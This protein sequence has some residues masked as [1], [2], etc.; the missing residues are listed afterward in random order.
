[1]SRRVIIDW[2]AIVALP[3][4]AVG[5]LVLLGSNIDPCLA[6][7]PSC[8]THEGVAPRVVVVPAAV[9]WVLAAFDIARARRNR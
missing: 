6:P 7:S 8:R 2:A 3:V 5:A 1:M 9:L 4:V